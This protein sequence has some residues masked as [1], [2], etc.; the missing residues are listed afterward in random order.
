MRVGMSPEAAA[1]VL[2]ALVA[3]LKAQ[4]KLYELTS[5]EMSSMDKRLAKWELKQS[6]KKIVYFN[7]ILGKY[8]KAQLKEFKGLVI[9]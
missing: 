4:H 3:G 1:E 9:E 2:T 8:T 5:G 6:M 7:G